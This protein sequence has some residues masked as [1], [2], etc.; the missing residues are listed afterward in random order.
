MKLESKRTSLFVH[1]LAFN[2]RTFE[3]FGE[4]TVLE[5]ENFGEETVL[6]VEDF[7]EE[8]VFEGVRGV[9]AILLFLHGGS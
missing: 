6:E 1:F 9:A 5:V 2:S 3:N 7:G 8:I 4:E